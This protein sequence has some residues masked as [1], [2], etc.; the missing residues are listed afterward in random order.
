MTQRE[1]VLGTVL[2][3]VL[4]VVGGGGAF[5]LFALQPYLDASERLETARTELASKQGDL[6]KEQQQ[7]AAVTKV[8][9][10]LALWREIS[11]PT[12]SPEL[13]ANKRFSSAEER[14]DQ[15]LRHLQ[16]EY[17]LYLDGL[18]QKNG[19]LPNSTII[20]PRPV[21]RKSNPILAGKVPV[22]ERMAFSVSGQATLKDVVRALEEFHRT[23]LLQ[24]VRSVNLTLVEDKARVASKRDRLMP[25]LLNVTMNVE[26]LMVT[27]GQERAGLLPSKLKTSPR[28]LAEPQRSYA[29]LDVKHPFLGYNPGAGVSRYSEDPR[30]VLRFVILN[31]LSLH[32]RRKIWEAYYYNQGKGGGD[33][34]LNATDE[35]EDPSDRR[36]SRKLKDIVI[37]DK[38]ENEVL[39][40]TV[41]LVDE[42]QMVFKS[43]GKFY[44]VL[45]GGFFGD[46]LE[47]PL[48]RAE[49]KR[50]NLDPAVMANAD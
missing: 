10:R 38:Y 25:G 22:Y 45:L 39:T 14:K 13:K 41:V 42:A 33:V 21:D 32:P 16:I 17:D 49:I 30:E 20:A 7:I 36:N 28:V 19:F 15:H 43:G 2:L 29:V 47:S 37:R 12:M 18:L 5:F 44:R 1:R 26:A 46:A 50:L 31:T 34:R 40:G 23:P 48:S 35:L 6:A 8:S 4:A 27:G 3:G 11:L 24:Q 9:P